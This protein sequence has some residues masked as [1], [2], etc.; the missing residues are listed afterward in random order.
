MSEFT[1][2]V[3]DYIYVG[4]FFPKD[5]SAV[6]SPRFGSVSFDFIEFNYYE[7]SHETE[8]GCGCRSVHPGI[9]HTHKGFE[10]VTLQ[11][12]LRALNMQKG[13]HN[14]AELS[15]FKWVSSTLQV[16]ASLMKKAG[17]SASQE[18]LVKKNP[19]LQWTHREGILGG[20]HTA[21]YWLK[22]RYQC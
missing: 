6:I 5:S 21:L 13:S 1:H 22:R 2:K 16:A 9:E 14:H 12:R 10:E 15:S 18:D 3:D 8:I 17:A 7:A 11:N 4:N 20:H 19:E